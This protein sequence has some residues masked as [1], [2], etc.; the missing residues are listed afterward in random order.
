MIG[1]S[2][3]RESTGILK[4]SSRRSDTSNR[5]M[6][7]SVDAKMSGVLAGINIDAIRPQATVSCKR[8]AKGE[9]LSSLPEMETCL[10]TKEYPG[11]T[12]AHISRNGGNGYASAPHFILRNVPC[13]RVGYIQVCLGNKCSEGERGCALSVFRCNFD[14]TC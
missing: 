12:L 2:D 1:V 13:V 8:Q 9:R 14:V 3:A 4:C 5:S 10:P 7:M 11:A 6:T